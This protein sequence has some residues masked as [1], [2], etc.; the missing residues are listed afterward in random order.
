M[1]P[2][3][4]AQFVMPQ[5]LF[6]VIGDP[7]G[8]VG[9]PS[10]G[11]GNNNGIGTGNHGGVGDKDGPGTGDKTGIG[12]EGSPRTITGGVSAPTIVYRVEPEYSEEARKARYQGTVVLQTVIRRD[13]TVD[14]VNVVRSLGF[15]LDQNAIQAL[16][17]WRFR[18]AMYNGSAV[19]VTINIEVNFNLR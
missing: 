16:K 10:P 15:G 13:G 8:V 12:S 3:I 19:D 1:E 18:P 14:V 4:V 2:T 11:P 7:K 6:S 5:N 9:P 17:Q